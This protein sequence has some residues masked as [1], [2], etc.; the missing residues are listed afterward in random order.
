MEHWGG[1]VAPEDVHQEGDRADEVQDKT[2]VFVCWDSRGCAGGLG[3]KVRG[4]GEGGVGGEWSGR[5]SRGRGSG[6]GC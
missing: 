5:T 1:E 3:G 6:G 4:E 2:V